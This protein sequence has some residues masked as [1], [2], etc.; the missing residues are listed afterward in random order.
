MRKVYE[1]TA[2]GPVRGPSSSRQMMG[3]GYIVPQHISFS[4][5]IT[6]SILNAR[7]S[8]MDTDE[9]KVVSYDP[10]ATITARKSA[11][12]SAP[13]PIFPSST[14]TIRRRVARK[15]TRHS[16]SGDGGI[17]RSLSGDS[18]VESSES[19]DDWVP[20]KSI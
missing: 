19:D 9:F 3:T 8:F 1:E 13:I 4:E 17:P 5:D 11:T 16:H 15:S 10:D 7:P 6:T 14:G 2:S 12:R 20:G 18:P